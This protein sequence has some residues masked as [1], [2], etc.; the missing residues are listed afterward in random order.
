MSGAIECLHAQYPGRYITDIE[1]SCN[2]IYENNPH[3]TKLDGRGER[4]KME[5]N[6]IHQSNQRP[7]HF[8]QGYVEHLG[9]KL[10]IGLQTT[11]N[12]P[13]LYLSDQEKGW[14]NQVEETTGYKGKYWLINSGYK[15]DFPVKHWPYYQAVVDGLKGEIQFVQVGEASPTHHHEPLDGVINLVGKTSSRQLIRL[16]YNSAGGIGGESF[17]HHIYAALQKPFVCLASGMTGRTW[18]QYQTEAYLSM[19]GRLPCC[20]SG[21]C[22]KKY[23]NGPSG[24]ACTFPDGQY[25]KCMTMIPATDAIAAIRSFYQGDLVRA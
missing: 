13:F 24:S 14:T 9:A 25:P 7:V 3:I 18:Q 2:A 15:D 6:L 10:G 12:R 20:H 1:T 16:A 11:V 19:Q 4:L 21:G 17:L 22:W 23:V 8:I 5:Y